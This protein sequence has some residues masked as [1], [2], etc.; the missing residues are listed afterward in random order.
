MQFAKTSAMLAAL[1]VTTAGCS[2]G[3]HSDA[4]WGSTAAPITSGHLVAGST[5]T[6]PLDIDVTSPA[7]ASW[8]A[9]PDVVVSGVVRRPAPSQ[10]ATV[11]LNGVPA[12]LGPK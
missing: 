6:I 9:S 8:L 11:S 4:R 12:T 10:I 3:V 2:Q 1:A 7:R 5:A